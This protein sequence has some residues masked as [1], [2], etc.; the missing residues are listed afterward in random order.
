MENTKP[1]E[2]LLAIMFA[3]M[4]TGLGQLYAGKILRGVLFFLIPIIV[5]IPAI[6]YLFN[7]NTT[8]SPFLLL[9]FIV[10]VAYGIFVIVD[11]YRCTKAYNISNNLTRSITTGRK[12]LLIVGIVFFG[13]ILNPSEIV[14]RRIGLYVR[15]NMVQAFKLPSTTMVPTLLLGDRFFVDKI[16][17]K[18][19]EPK[20]GDVIVFIDP[21]GSKRVFVKRLI[22][23]PEET[24][25]IKNGS[26]LINGTK[27][28]DPSLADKYYYNAGDY[29]KEGQAVKIPGDGYYV[30]GDDS[31]ASKDSRY[32]G[33]V[34]NKHLIGK[35]YKIYYPF[36]RSGA[37]K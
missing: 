37:I 21:E 15:G 13:F 34:P 9:L 23:L 32:F 20:R 30:L 26:I 35:A 3:I 6:L 4:V 1:K 28:N 18:K 17:Y 33:F 16:I 22:G 36:S 5:V 10:G 12:A 19:S 31:A 11:A 29:A 7:P 27:V 24:I 2:P 8:T 25:E 14:S